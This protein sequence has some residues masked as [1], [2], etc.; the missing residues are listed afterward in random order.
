MLHVWACQTTSPCSL[1]RAYLIGWP[2]VCC[3]VQ[4]CPFVRVSCRSPNSTSPTRTSRQH[5]SS[6]LTQQV[7][8]AWFPCDMLVTFQRGC[9]KDAARMQQGNCS[10]GISALLCWR[11]WQVA[12]LFRSKM[13]S[14]AAPLF[15]LTLGGF[16]ASQ[17]LQYRFA[18]CKLNNKRHK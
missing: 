8:H 14:V 16:M 13:S 9:H 11:A 17:N 4:C 2:V 12:G 7:R 6:I 5:P 10:R 15:A 1:P 3:N 18:V